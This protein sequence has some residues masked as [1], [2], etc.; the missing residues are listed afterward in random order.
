MVWRDQL[1]VGHGTFGNVDEQ[2]RGIWLFDKI[3]RAVLHR[4]DRGRDIAMTGDH[5]DGHVIIDLFD[6][7][8][9]F[10]TIHLGHADVGNNHPGPAFAQSGKCGS[11]IGKDFDMN[12]GKFKRLLCGFTHIGIIV[13]KQNAIGGGWHWRIL[14]PGS[15][16]R[17]PGQ[18]S[19]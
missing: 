16:I 3:E 14:R 13:N 11:G 8:Q 18:R 4:L 15:R 19:A 10:Q 17:T 2:I 1:A 5:D 6:F 9:K 12:V 7:A